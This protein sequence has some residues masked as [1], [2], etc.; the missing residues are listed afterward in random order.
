M[1]DVN[2]V[3]VWGTF[4]VADHLRHRSS[5]AG[6]RGVGVRMSGPWHLYRAL[7]SAAC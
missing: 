2:D 6:V 4:S 7:L 5:V 1:P 3:S